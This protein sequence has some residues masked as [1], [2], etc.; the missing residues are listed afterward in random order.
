[1]LSTLG[2]LPLLGLKGQAGTA[3]TEELR[4]W[5]PVVVELQPQ[6]EHSST[7]RTERRKKC[8][9]L[10]SLP[11]HTLKPL[12]GASHC[13]NQLEGGEQESLHNAVYA[14]STS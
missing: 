11:P 10:S 12:F 13:L 5:K 8:L 9:D 3:V 7:A 6:P 4:K 1:M 2:L 14:V